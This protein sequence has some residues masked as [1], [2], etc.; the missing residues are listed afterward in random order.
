MS[1]QVAAQQRNVGSGMAE[2]Q[3]A[4]RRGATQRISALD[5]TKGALVLI[6]VLYHW[7]NYF[8]GSQ[9]P[10]Y[11]YLRFL[12]PSFIFITGFLISHIYFSK[13]DA[14][15]PRL[16]KRLF[17]RGLKLMV[18]FI[19]L[20]AARA[21]VLP[22]L[23]TGSLAAHP[24]AA[25]NFV[26]VYLTGNLPVTSKL[27]SFSILIPIA[28]LLMLSAALTLALRFYKYT[29][30]AAC[31][32]LLLSILGLAFIGAHSQNL[33][34]VTVGMLGVL[35]GFIPI[36]AINRFVRHPYMLA[37]SYLCYVITITIV[38]VPYPLLIVGVCL[39][40]MAIY[41]VGVSEGESNRIRKEIILLGKYSLLGYIAQIA[42][43]QILFASFRHL[44]LGV[45]ALF[46]SFFAA[47]ALTVASVEGVDRARTA[48]TSI[49]KLYKT[50]FA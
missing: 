47:F 6:M 12:T 39:S 17:V 2:M 35:I 26:T 10:Y 15:D 32:F 33:E 24:L 37:F 31:G 7:I 50:V 38:N 11:F 13:Y 49:D 40:L 21:L 3:V 19:V 46:L 23:S 1:N 36:A 18:I 16:P 30:H 28:Y 8:I 27:V 34:F 43:L 29:F 9:W 25:Q 41:L 20:N 42:I 5:F 14:A 44:N 48:A 4:E 45:A 22:I